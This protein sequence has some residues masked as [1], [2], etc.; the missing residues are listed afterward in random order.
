MLS[1]VLTFSLNLRVDSAHILVSILAKILIII[2]FPSSSLL[3]NELKS[4]LTPI[5]LGAI[6]PISGKFPIVLVA[7]LLM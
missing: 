3:S 7:F 1:K 4:D 6:E 2:F 5:N